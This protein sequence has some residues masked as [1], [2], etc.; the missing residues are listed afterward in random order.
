MNF[1]LSNIIYPLFFVF[2]V[3]H[4]AFV[5]GRMVFAIFKLHEFQKGMMAHALST[6]L[7]YGI[8][9]HITLI[10][11]FFGSL[12]KP[13][14]ILFLVSVLLIGY[15]Y[16][17]SLYTQINIAIKN[18][19]NDLL[20]KIL[21]LGILIGFIFYFSSAFVPPYRTDALAYH[22]PEAMH[23]SNDG[24]QLTGLEG[25][26]FN[27]L[28][29]LMEVLFALLY[30]ISGFTA[31][32]LTHFLI[33]I[34]SIFFMYDFVKIWYGKKAALLSVLM[35]FT[36]YELFVNAA[37]SY[38]DAGTL[39]YEVV[40]FLLLV[41]YF[42]HQRRSLLLL[43]GFFYGFAIAIKYN[44]LYGLVIASFLFFIFSVYKKIQIKIL[45]K[46]ICIFLIAVFITGGF[47]YVKNLFLYGN[48]VYP[49]YFGHPGFSDQQYKD[50]VDTVKLILVNKSLSNFLLL[51][52]HFFL[53][54]YYIPTFLSFVSLPVSFFVILKDKS[55]N[56]ELGT[57][58]FF[59]IITYLLCWFFLA[60]HQ[61]RFAFVPIFFAFI[62]FGIL[63]SKLSDILPQKINLRVLVLSGLLIVFMFGYGIFYAKDSYFL[64]VKKTEI[65]YII[66][67]Y[68]KKDFYHNRNLGTAYEISQY[69]NNHYINTKFLNIWST[70]DFFLTN[71]NDFLSPESLY[72][73]RQFSTTTMINFLEN[74]DVKYVLIDEFERSQAFNESVRTGNPAYIRYRDFVL[75]VEDFVVN[76]GS[77]VVDQYGAEIYVLDN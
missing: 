21:I 27:N 42:Q 57:F 63:L 2:V 66:G 47:W 38:I 6:L 74:M 72:Y 37:N 4:A 11:S 70:N 52:Y 54:S 58:M 45:L 60:T 46:N 23:I 25:N 30:T 77:K 18:T 1:I 43:S 67:R 16:I 53:S 33:L 5:L 51:P 31:I 61:I 29:L 75:L 28:P 48:P 68:T 32:H 36:M 49:F 59:Y 64:N 40:G 34:S 17:F 12:N 65:L 15:K 71:N 24:L 3:L 73:S 7:G 76:T 22:L 44:A 62:F 50:L 14:L 39:A 10:F 8:I 13:V 19:P 35:I 55:K 69:I 26:F 20:E 41:F 56:R 9:A